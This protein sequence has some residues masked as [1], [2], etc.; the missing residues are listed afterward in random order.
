MASLVLDASITD[1]RSIV[2]SQVESI[3]QFMPRTRAYRPYMIGPAWI[4]IASSLIFHNYDIGYIIITTRKL[5]AIG[6]IIIIVQCMCSGGARA[7]E[8]HPLGST[9]EVSVE[10]S[11]HWTIDAL[12][13]S[14]I[15]TF[16][17]PP[18]K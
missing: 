13:M 11:P 2:D 10:Q 8:P 5:I 1:Y 9:P 18:E 16:E 7:P 4:T 14:L 12:S 3:D 15:S 6:D 17:F